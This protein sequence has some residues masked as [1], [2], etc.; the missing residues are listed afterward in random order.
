MT[1]EYKV[2]HPAW[3]IFDTKEYTIDVDFKIVY[4]EEFAFLQNMTPDSVFLS[5]GSGIILRKGNVIT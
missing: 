2:E 5:E 1:Q 3:K 4:G